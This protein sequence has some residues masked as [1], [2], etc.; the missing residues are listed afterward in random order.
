VFHT[1]IIKKY[2]FMRL[3]RVVDMSGV[4]REILASVQ[5]YDKDH[6]L[7]RLREYYPT[8]ESMDWDFIEE[9]ESHHFVGIMGEDI[10]L[11]EKTPISEA[12]K[13]ILH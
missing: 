3:S 11:H 7:L 12:I 2:L 10:P 1:K 8:V 6:A 4:R 5:A 13:K 9:L